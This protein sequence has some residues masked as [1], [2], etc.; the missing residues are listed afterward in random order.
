MGSQCSKVKK[1]KMYFVDT[2][3][4]SILHKNN[5]MKYT[6]YLLRCPITKNI[7]YVGMTNNIK[8]RFYEHCCVK[9]RKSKLHIEWLKQLRIEKKIPLL[10]ILH[11]NLDLNLAIEYEKK[12]IKE[13]DNLFNI[14]EGGIM[15]P[16]TKG[17]RF[18][19]KTIQK[20]IITSPL[21]KRVAQFDENDNLI[22]EF[23]GVREA[24]R[25]TKIDH[26]SIAA[27]ASGSKIRKTAGGYKWKYI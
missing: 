26:R 18:S 13:Y 14:L 2:K 23:I 24:C 15:P 9:N 20:K 22:S 4:F 8:R 17:K 7:K 25:Q 5:F 27:V 19:E 11:D 21:K 1:V 3:I 16:S 12:Y 6:I 10:E